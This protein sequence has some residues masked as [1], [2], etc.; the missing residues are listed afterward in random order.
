MTMRLNR[1]NIQERMKHYKV[2]GI[3]MAQ[4][5]KGEISSSEVFG[6][7]E[8]G[9]NN[10]VKSDSIFNACSISKFVTSMLVMRLIEQ[11]LLD[12]DED[13]N[14]K[15]IS[16]KVPENEFT[17]IKKVT[18][19]TLLCH[20]SGL[21]DP[22]DSFGE[23]NFTEGI[24]TMIDLLG[25]LTSYCTESIQVKYEPG[26]EFQYSDAGFCVIQQLI[27]DVSGEPF[28]LVMDELIFKP[29]N[30]KNSTF[31]H[32]IS[33]FERDGFACGHNKDGEVVNGKYSMYPYPA[34]SGLWSTSEDLAFLVIELL[35]S[36]DGNG[37][38][39]L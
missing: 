22:K 12:L 25:G 17:I 11:G 19:R 4:F 36:L 18:L 23:L 14:T 6:V 39:A 3:S 30:M 29:L 28:D 16:W 35:K 2:P 13:V 37:K 20:Q 31:D 9:S 33:R 38:L 1:M 32:A 34:A 26:S 10:K 21:I 7:I 27:E 15:L 24:P 8:V 5:V